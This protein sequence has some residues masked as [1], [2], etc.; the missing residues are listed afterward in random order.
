MSEIGKAAISI[1]IKD[2]TAPALAKINKTVDD[3]TKN[4]TVSVGVLTAGRIGPSGGGGGMGGG[5]AGGGGGAMGETEKQI[6]EQGKTVI[7]AEAAAR[8]L[9]GAAKGVTQGLS[10]YQNALDEGV[11]KHEAVFIA[12]QTTIKTLV[13]SVPIVGEMAVSWYEAGQGIA[14]FIGLQEDYAKKLNELQAEQDKANK[15]AR[16]R[17]TARLAAEKS[18]AEFVK[19]I[20]RAS[21]DSNVDE[22]GKKLNE[23]NDKREAQL[24]EVNKAVLANAFSA[25]SAQEATNKIEEATNK[26]RL[27]LIREANNKAAEAAANAQKNLEAIGA[28]VS[29]LSFSDTETN[30]DVAK[31]ESRLKSLAKMRD[32]A[33]AAGGSIETLQE[34]EK[35]IEAKGKEAGKALV[36]ALAKGVQ[37]GLKTT[38]QRVQEINTSTAAITIGNQNLSP[39]E[40][41]NA[42]AAQAKTELQAQFAGENAAVA[43]D[44]QKRL[45]LAK[46]LDKRTGGVAGAVADVEKEF[47]ALS[48]A[49]SKNQKAQ[50]DSVDVQLKKQLADQEAQKATKLADLEQQRAG[51]QGSIDEKIKALTYSVSGFSTTGTAGQQMQQENIIKDQLQELKKS[52][53]VLAT[54]NK[55]IVALN[56]GIPIQ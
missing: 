42:Q 56:S 38:A 6:L 34:I 51:M 52:N 54:I 50:L 22:L 53:D 11:S 19:G 10:D 23:L 16:E 12:L 26:E 8:V 4:R 7:K 15:G 24:E 37:D 9:A 17:S 31:F 41:A 35:Q 3:A 1:S 45:D 40:L 47:K 43:E 28:R 13:K 48:D 29:E 14:V 32:E 36:D 33:K 2:L 39:A 55:N 46:E 18:I 30:S 49:M 5:A 44:F 27:R 21:R 20:D 25:T